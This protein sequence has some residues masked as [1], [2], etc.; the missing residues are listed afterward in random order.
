[1]ELEQPKGSIAWVILARLQVGRPDLYI[2]VQLGGAGKIVGRSFHYSD[3][4]R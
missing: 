3:S 1:M 2:K 4:A